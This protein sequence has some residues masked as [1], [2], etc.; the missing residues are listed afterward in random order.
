MS[1]KSVHK[2]L[3]FTVGEDQEVCSNGGFLFVVAGSPAENEQVN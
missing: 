1:E 2:V 3:L